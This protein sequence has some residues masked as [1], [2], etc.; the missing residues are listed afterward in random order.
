MLGLRTVLHLV[1]VADARSAERLADR[2]LVAGIDVTVREGAEGG[3]ELWVVDDERLEAAQAVLARDDDDERETRRKAKALRAEQ[4][5]SHRD[6]ASRSVDLR[7]RWRGA[8]GTELA[9]LSTMLVVAS[10]M[11]AWSTSL[12]DPSTPTLQALSIE[13]WLSSERFGQVMQGE[14]WRLVTPMF[15]HFGFF[16]LLFNMSWVLTFGPQIERNHGFATMLA[17]VVLSE[18]AGSIPQYYATGP[19]F[20]GMSGVVYGLFGF[21]WMHARFG[22]GSRYVLT[23]REAVLSIVW[24]IACGSGWLG[25]IAN[26]GHA[27]GLVVGLL[28]GTP[29]Y[30]QHLRARR[31]GLAAVEHSWANTYGTP[32]LRFRHRVVAGYVPLW[33]LLIAIAVGITDVLR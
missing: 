12:G 13:P 18:L 20:G 27:G 6:H 24:L 28:M 29:A 15:I 31:S 3:R 7:T 33:L 1:D 9:P 4:A 5:A 11:V 23:D 21:V 22:P 32:W 17:L 16:H 2:L 19:S 14:I 8:T 10:V 30:V 25:P 26:L